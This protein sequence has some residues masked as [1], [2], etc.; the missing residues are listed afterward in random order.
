M[1]QQEAEKSLNSVNMHEKAVLDL[2]LAMLYLGEGVKSGDRTSIGNSDPLILKSFVYMMKNH[3][4]VPESKLRCDLYLR[5]DQN[6]KKIKSFWSK[7]LNLPIKN[8]K[9]VNIDKRTIGSK[10]YPDY[11]GV[12]AITCGNVAIKRKLLNIGRGFCERLI[13]TRP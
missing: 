9:F 1:A 8:F 11:K 13:S 12:C 10:T 7:E 2:A 4:N 5:A 3:Y 6:P